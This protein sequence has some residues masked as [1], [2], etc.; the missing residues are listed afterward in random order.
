MAT[1][2]VNSSEWHISPYWSAVDG[3]TSVG[4]SS[5]AVNDTIEFNQITVIDT[6]YLDEPVGPDAPATYF[7]GGVRDG[8]NQDFVIYCEGSITISTG[9]FDWSENPKFK[10]YSIEDQGVITVY[11]RQKTPVPT[12][13]A[14]GDNAVAFLKDKIENAYT[15]GTN[16]SISGGVIS[17]TDTTYSNFTGTDGI[18]PGAAGLVPAPTT[19]DGSKFLKGDGTWAAASSSTGLVEMSYGE[20][21]AWAKFI[22]AYTA[23]SIVYCRASSNSN[24]A[25]GSQTR[26]AFMAYVN[27]ASSPTTVEFQ[28]IR[29]IESHSATQQGDQVYVYKLTNSNGGTWSVSVREMSTKIVAGTHMSSSYSSGA[30]T[31]NASWPT[32]NNA[33]LTIQQNGVSAGTFT[34]NASSDNTISLTDTTYSA[35]TG[36][37]SGDAGTAG[38]VPAPAAGDESKCLAGDGT[39]K[40]IITDTGWIDC[41]YKSGYQTS[42]NTGWLKLQAR[43]LNGALYLRGGV[44]PSSGTFNLNSEYNV[45]TLPSSII[46]MITTTSALNCTG[47]SASSGVSLWTVMNDGSGEIYLICVA[48]NTGGRSWASAPGCIGLVD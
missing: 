28:Y 31:L 2:S 7:L 15:A 6:D 13:K 12:G 23:G 16:V 21:N 29:S 11:V 35:F 48:T 41:P 3:S 10:V 1:I 42:S 32:V 30:L 36:A 45:A 19:S 39:W 46:S 37:T 27:D 4:S 17:A 38:L 5:I 33:T 40:T 47:R 22:N 43:V 9:M 25:S 34:A 26:K 44:S 18:N 14:L 20:S 8:N 24:P